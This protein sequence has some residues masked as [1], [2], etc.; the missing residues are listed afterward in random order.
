MIYFSKQF[1]RQDAKR[2]HQVF[3]S[4]KPEAQAKEEWVNVKGA[5]EKPSLTLP[6]LKNV[7]FAFLNFLFEALVS[8]LCD[9]EEDSF[10]VPAALIFFVCGA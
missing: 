1:H 2:N 5:V 3:L 4:Y 8:M 9:C 7:F 6:A 10:T